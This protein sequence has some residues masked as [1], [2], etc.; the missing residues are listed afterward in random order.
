LGSSE[1]EFR[2]MAIT[3]SQKIAFSIVMDSPSDLHP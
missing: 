1:H 2:L 3:A